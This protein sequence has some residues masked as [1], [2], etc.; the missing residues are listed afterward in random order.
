[1]SKVKTGILNKKKGFCKK[2]WLRISVCDSGIGIKREDLERIFKSFE[3]VDSESNRHYQGTGLGLSLTR[4]LIE[5]HKG[6]IWAESPGPDQGSTFSF[7]L[8]L[9]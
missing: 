4:N 5:L 8:P 3:Q 6:K 9:S 2:K 7:T 1:M